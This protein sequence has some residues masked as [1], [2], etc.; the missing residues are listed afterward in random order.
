MAPVFSNVVVAGVLLFGGALIACAPTE[1]AGECTSTKP[2]EAR[3]EACD[4]VLQEC[5][6]Q[7]LDVDATSDVDAPA[8]FSGVALPFF[9][10]EVCM[11]NRV[12][13]GDTI[14][15][16][17]NPCLHPCIDPGGF[18]FKKQFSC[19]G[20]FCKSA[21]IQMF[22][23]AASG[24]GGCTKDAFAS[25]DRSQCVYPES[26]IKA[27]A[28]P[29]AVD[30]NP[31]RGNAEVEIPFLTNDDAKAI[32]DGATTADIWNLINQ[33]PASDERVFAISMDGANPAAP[34]DCSDESKCD[35]REIGF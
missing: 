29:L 10:G 21:V 17:I 2:C 5:V 26:P 32:R 15:V 12:Q 7:D 33:Y 27:N 30:G 13:P 14:P 28:G 16:S 3:G 24:A 4:V 31:I 23:N 25:F 9:R 20:A 19:T 11:P 1:S 8:N 6:V 22:V 34:A 35:C 18:S